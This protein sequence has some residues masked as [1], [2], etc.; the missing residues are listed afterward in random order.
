MPFDYLPIIKLYDSSGNVIEANKGTYTHLTRDILLDLRFDVD[1]LGVLLGISG[2]N[3]TSNKYNW[4]KGTTVA[5]DTEERLWLSYIAD[6]RTACEELRIKANTLPGVS[7]PAFDWTPGGIG[8]ET[9][10]LKPLYNGSGDVILGNKGTYTD[11]RLKSLYETVRT[12]L[13]AIVSALAIFVDAV[14]GSDTTGDGSAGNPYQTWNKGIDIINTTSFF[15]CILKPGTYTADRSLIAYNSIIE[16]TNL[17]DATILYSPGISVVDTAWYITLNNLIFGSGATTPERVFDGVSFDSSINNCIFRGKQGAGQGGRTCYISSGYQITLNHCTILCD[18]EN[19]PDRGLYYTGNNPITLNN[20]AI[21]NAGIGIT[22]P[23]GTTVNEDY[24]VLENCL[25]DRST[26]IRNI[27][28]EH[29]TATAPNI[30]DINFGHL[31]ND[32]DYIGA[33]SAGKD[34]GAYEDGPYNHSKQVSDIIGANE[35]AATTIAIT[36]FDSLNFVEDLAELNLNIAVNMFLGGIFRSNTSG[37]VTYLDSSDL[38]SQPDVPNFIYNGASLDISWDNT[39]GHAYEVHIAV[40]DGSTNYES[41]S[42]WEVNA[43]FKANIIPSNEGINGNKYYALDLYKD[44]QSNNEWGSLGSFSA[45]TP[46]TGINDQKWDITLKVRI[47]DIV[48]QKWSEVVTVPKTYNFNTFEQTM[49]YCANNPRITNDEYADHANYSLQ[50]YHTDT[51]NYVRPDGTPWAD[52]NRK[53]AYNPMFKALNHVFG[54]L[55]DPPTA[56]FNPVGLWTDRKMGAGTPA[57]PA[58]RSLF[59]LYISIGVNYGN[60]SEGNGAVSDNHLFANPTTA[61]PSDSGSANFDFPILGGGSNNIRYLQLSGYAGSDCIVHSSLHGYIARMPSDENYVLQDFS[62]TPGII[63]SNEVKYEQSDDQFPVCQPNIHYYCK[64]KDNS[65]N[66]SSGF[67]FW[68]FTH[69]KYFVNT[70][71]SGN[72]SYGEVWPLHSHAGNQSFSTNW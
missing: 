27:T 56:G 50:Q 62:G 41:I 8:V 38:S 53:Y 23:S 15:K 17:G 69:Q 29:T 7:I 24:C 58:F 28:N 49:Y 13:I 11:I 40:D 44:T 55:T 61:R 26:Y 31:N 14:N 57:F 20:V 6:L 66:F 3:W 10:D 63:E 30:I 22:A 70:D 21:L 51:L 65:G 47:K 71:G 46:V 42:W 32:S 9:I 60:W 34:I 33:S 5:L 67:V 45:T 43:V 35:S 19:L 39:A 12:S 36:A 48:A 18:P 1:Y 59:G 52:D 72:L 4:A 64:V 54:H 16:A 68:Q 25:T 37:V 2:P